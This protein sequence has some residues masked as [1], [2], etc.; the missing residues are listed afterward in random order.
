MAIE[1]KKEE[2]KGL[3]ERQKALE[4]ALLQIEKQ[5]GRWDV[6]RR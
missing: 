2:S 6:Q 5:F 1:K 3:S 4:L